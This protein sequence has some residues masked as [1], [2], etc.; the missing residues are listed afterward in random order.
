MN[1]DWMNNNGLVN[2]KIPANTECPW[3]VKCEIASLGRCNHKGKE[4]DCAFSCSMAR[5]FAIIEEREKKESS[6]PLFGY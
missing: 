6:Q 4:H 1:N 3:L 5:G 2:G